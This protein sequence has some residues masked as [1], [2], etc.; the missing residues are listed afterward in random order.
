MKT[1]LIIL[2]VCFFSLKANAAVMEMYGKEIYGFNQPKYNEDYSENSQRYIFMIS[3]LASHDNFPF[4]SYE[5]GS[6]FSKIFRDIQEVTNVKISIRYNKKRYEEKIKEFER[7]NVIKGEDVNARFGVYYEEYPYSKNSFVYPAFFENT[8]HLIMPV[9]KKLSL[10]GKSSLKNYKGVYAKTDNLPV[11]VVKNLSALGAEEVKDLPEAF[12]KILTGKADYIAA[13][14]Y[15]SLI[16]SYKQGIRK[17]VLFSKMPVWKAPMF[18]RVLPEVMDD[19]RM[20]ELKKYLKSS[21]YKKVRDDA[22]KELVQIY[23][24]NTRGIVP[25]TYINAV[26][27]QKDEDEFEE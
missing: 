20:E 15:P 21:H 18:F 22:F 25:P 27:V 3:A 8:I 23:E 19:K 6:V 1:V 14:Y 11:Y 5:Q 7:G 2:A 13:S 17:Y 26:P 24:E 4:S 16:E 12:E 10:Q 9:N